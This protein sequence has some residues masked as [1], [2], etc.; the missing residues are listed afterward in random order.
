MNRLH[1]YRP[2]I[3]SLKLSSDLTVRSGPPKRQR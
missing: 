1:A 2:S 3:G